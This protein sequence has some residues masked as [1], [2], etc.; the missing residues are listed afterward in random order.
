MNG[1]SLALRAPESAPVPEAPEQLQIAKVFTPELAES[2]GYLPRVGTVV[3]RL[4]GDERDG[5]KPAYFIT[6]GDLAAKSRNDLLCRNKLG[7]RAVDFIEEVLARYGL[8]LKE[9]VQKP[10]R[11]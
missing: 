2:L 4:A 6:L 8:A 9:P 5:R 10:K 1:I 11:H 7:P 3:R